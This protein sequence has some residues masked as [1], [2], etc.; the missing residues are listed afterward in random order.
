MNQPRV[1]QERV[2]M[3]AAGTCS[4]MP[5]IE[6][7]LAQDLLDARARL[8]GAEAQVAALRAELEEHQWAD[9]GSCIE[10]DREM[11]EAGEHYTDC[12]VAAVL[13]DTAQAAREWE[14]RMRAEVVKECLFVIDSTVDI[15][16]SDLATLKERVRA[17]GAGPADSKE[18]E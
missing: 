13:A 9:N 17:L 6:Q 2:E 16:R 15:E 14:E 8:A 7:R 11:N 4:H 18:K 12:H 3:E 1:S 10:C 5:G